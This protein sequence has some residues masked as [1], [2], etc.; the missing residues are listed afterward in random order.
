MSKFER[1]IR[2]PL[3]MGGQAR[4]RD[5]GITV[6]EIVRLSLAGSSQAE[7]LQQFPALEAEDVYQA[8][9]YTLGEL[10][11]AFVSKQYET[12]DKI[13]EIRWPA[14]GLTE[15]NSTEEIKDIRRRILK[16]CQYL[17]CDIDINLRLEEFLVPKP[18]R[19][20]EIWTDPI[21]VLSIQAS[22]DRAETNLLIHGFWLDWKLSNEQIP[23][24]KTKNFGNL[25]YWLCLSVL[26][27]E[28]FEFPVKAET[29]YF[30]LR[31]AMLYV[32][33]PCY[34]MFEDK[35]NRFTLIYKVLGVNQAGSL[36]AYRLWKMGSELKIREEENS[37]IF[38]FALPIVE[39]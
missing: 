2:E 21:D 27:A 4:V 33:I 29:V 31:D 30:A 20:L 36:A 23:R 5:T 10:D 12:S 14:L 26:T 15:N 6:N 13:Q 18:R 11:S 3:V 1:I 25:L 16:R 8:L 19:Y 38:E 7:I 32:S 9:S 39:E 35:L 28:E 17:K 37:V 22:L 34:G 24:L